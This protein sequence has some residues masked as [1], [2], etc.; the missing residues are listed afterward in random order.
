MDATRS[1]AM[2]AMRNVRNARTRIA[3]RRAA[4]A[5]ANAASKLLP[6]ITTIRR[7]RLVEK[8]I[9]DT[10]FL[11]RFSIR[12]PPLEQHAVAF[13]AARIGKADSVAGRVA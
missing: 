9:V 11:A 6:R 12:E 7:I 2:P 5:A 8:Q 3:V 1:G 4:Q 10:L 13:R